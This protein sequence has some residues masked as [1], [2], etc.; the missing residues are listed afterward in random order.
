MEKTKINNKGFSLVELIIVIAIM[1][2]LAAA[3]APQLMK[4]INKS[5]ESS[6]NST[7]G[8]IKNSVNTALSEDEVYK[9]CKGQDLTV[10][11]KESAKWTNAGAKLKAELEEKMPDLK[12]PKQSDKDHWEIHIKGNSKGGFEV[13]VEAKASS[14]G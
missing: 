2:I 6:D 14:N 9:E 7:A 3:L 13:T 10:T 8:S 11:Y 4:Y 12:D 1:A 5:R